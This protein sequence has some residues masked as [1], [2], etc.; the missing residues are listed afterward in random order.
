MNII[1][2]SQELS[3]AGEKFNALVSSIMNEC[4]ESGTKNDVFAYLQQISL[5]CHQINIISC[6]KAEMHY[7]DSGRRM[8]EAS[9][10]LIQN[11]ANLL[12]SII[13]YDF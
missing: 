3:N 13:L 12:H 1:E 2:A 8:T 6:V 5:F 11:S 10:S 4:V 7:S 9:T